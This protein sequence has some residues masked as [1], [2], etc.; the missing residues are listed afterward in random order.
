MAKPNK[1]KIQAA[2]EEYREL[3]DER[4]RVQTQFTADCKPAQTR[5]DN[6]VA[7]LK[8]TYETEIASLN[9]RVTKLESEI[10]AELMLGINEDGT[11]TLPQV[12]VD[13]VIAE[14]S[15][16]TTRTI[17]PQKFI[18]ATAPKAR[19]AKWYECVNVLITKVDKH[20]GTKFEALIDTVSKPSVKIKLVPRTEAAE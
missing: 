4:A 18:E 6:A 14:I 9:P 5:F 2:L 7:E 1:K 3:T 17:E 16:Q 12:A 13:G 20:F 11:I 19:D 15:Q 8:A 10:K